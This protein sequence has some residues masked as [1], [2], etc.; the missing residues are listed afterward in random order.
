VQHM[1]DPKNLIRKFEYGEQ[2]K[3]EVSIANQLLEQLIG[4][5][6]DQ[7]I[8]GLRILETYLNSLLMEIKLAQKVLHSNAIFA[9]TARKL[10]EAIGRISLKEYDEARACFGEALSDVTTVCAESSE[11]LAKLE[12]M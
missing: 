3:S 6:D 12:L 5:Q 2:L 1:A 7:F 11:A 10:T 8:G 9:Q 4:L